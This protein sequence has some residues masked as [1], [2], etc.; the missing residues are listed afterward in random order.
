[1]YLRPGR[2]ISIAAVCVALGAGVLA[3]CGGSHTSSAVPSSGGGVLKPQLNGGTGSLGT[4]STLYVS[5]QGAVYAY[6]LTSLT[7]P[8]P[9]P[10]AAVSPLPLGHT[11]GY[12]YQA[13][14]PGGVNA[15]IAGI[16]T[17]SAGDLVLVQNFTNPQGD[18]NACQLVYLT[19]R[20]VSDPRAPDATSVPCDNGTF[21]NGPPAHTPGTAVGVTFTGPEPGPS[22]TPNP[23]YVFSDDIDVLMHY[24]PTGNTNLH[25]C[26]TTSSEQYEVDR[27]QATAGSITTQG[28]PSC[29]VLPSPGPSPGPSA[30][31]YNYIA[32]ST[33]GN[34]FLDSTSVTVVDRVNPFGTVTASGT[35]PA[36]GPLAV[37]ANSTTSVGYRVVA[38]NS[39]GVTTIYTFKVVGAALSFTNALGTFTNPI[40]ALA[41]DNN[42]TVYVGVNQPGGVTKIKVYGP[43]KTQATSP[44]YILLNPVRRPN[45]SASPAAIITGIA[46]AQ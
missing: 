40:G 8:P 15:S 29:I 23:P 36:P 19:A 39:G 44:D 43:S 26:D 13:G 11:G 37:A 33:G 25:G 24:Q 30:G 16:A 1:M 34:V 9:S 46:I 20:L 27:Y 6:D 12:Y 14:G 45:P 35:I 38:S 5:G 17:N 7:S 41:V 3:G 32:G 10:G 2:I 18:G 22:A 28:A 4:A 31:P 21:N 42:G